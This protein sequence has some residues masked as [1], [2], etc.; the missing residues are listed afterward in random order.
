MSD[1]IFIRE[2]TVD[3]V[4]G[5]L[6]WE[7]EVRQTLRL[8]LELAADV[9]GP[10]ASDAI[11]EA[12]DYGA[13]AERVRAFAAASDYRLIESLAEAIAALLR[14]EFG[15]PWLRLRLCKP[16]AVPGTRD[17]GVLIERGEAP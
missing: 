11:A 5:V 14:R 6:D 17:V 7:R 16:G 12:L 3:T 10:A 15:I 8:D 13:V 4:I 1:R 2:L 9:A